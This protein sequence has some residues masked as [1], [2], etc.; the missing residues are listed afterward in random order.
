MFFVCAAFLYG[1]RTDIH[2]HDAQR[3]GQLVL[4]GASVLTMAARGLKVS[5]T[6]CALIVLSSLAAMS[7]GRWGLIE[8][9]HLVSLYMLAMLWATRLRDM[10]EPHLLACCVAL[11]GTYI[12]LLLPRWAAL[13]FENLSFH[14]QEF[15]TGFSNQRFF[16]HWVTLSLPLLVLARR[17]A[18]ACSFRS[19]LL[20]ALAGLWLCFVIASGTRGTWFALLAVAFAA[21]LAGRAGRSMASGMA[22]TA[23]IGMALYGLMFWLAPQMVS[24]DAG[25]EGLSRIAQGA[26][27]SG[28]EVLWS[29]AV[30]GITTRPLLGMGPMMFAALPNDYAA[31]PHNAVLQLAYEWGIPLTFL[32]VAFASTVLYRQFRICRQ[33]NDPLRVALLMCIVGGLIQ[34]QVDGV[35]VMPFSQVMFVLLCAWLASLNDGRAAQ[36][37]PGATSHPSAGFRALLLLLVAA[38]LWLISPELKRLEAWEEDFLQSSAK[39]RYFPRFWAQGFVP[40]V[41]QSVMPR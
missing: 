3:I 25:L 33:G 18:E 7:A 5:R 27:L 10:P 12:A 14:P 11:V 6:V 22:H 4:L 17:R 20:H 36:H 15:F 24:G 16:G 29:L 13:V 37:A 8:C 30:E 9:F 1:E 28:R 40:G 34:A 21:P 41:R 2:Q 38:Q 35:L 32:V 39:D 31:H 26:A 23:L 19:G